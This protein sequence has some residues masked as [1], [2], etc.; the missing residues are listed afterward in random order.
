MGLW[1]LTSEDL[2]LVNVAVPDPSSGIH[3]LESKRGI[4]PGKLLSQ[5]HSEAGGLLLQAPWS[6]AEKAMP[7]N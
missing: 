2:D 5:R 7:L 6:L 4:F 3:G 1:L